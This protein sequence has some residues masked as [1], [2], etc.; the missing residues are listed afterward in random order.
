MSSNEQIILDRIIGVVNRT[1]PDVEL[2]SEGFRERQDEIKIYTFPFALEAP[3]N[4]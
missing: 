1:A 4:N 3:I 2:Y